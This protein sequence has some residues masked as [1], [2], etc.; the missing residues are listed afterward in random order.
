MLNF[1]PEL[2][3][4][5]KGRHQFCHLVTLYLS[6]VIRYTDNDTDMLHNGDNYIT[7]PWLGMRDAKQS[8][9]PQINKIQLEFGGAD[10]T[11]IVLVGST[12]WMNS[13]VMIERAYFE[14]TGQHIVGILHYKSGRLESQKQR[15]SADKSRLSLFGSTAWADHKKQAGTRC[16]VESQQRFYPDD[17]GYELATRISD[18]EPWGKH[19]KVTVNTNTVKAR[20]DITQ[21]YED[22]AP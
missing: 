9:K 10:Q 22:E 14:E 17:F 8:S 19:R 3:A 7:G 5:I 11:L 21:R 1:S 18:N 12:T 20:K 4:A 15:H 6:T 13:K 16:N 2:S